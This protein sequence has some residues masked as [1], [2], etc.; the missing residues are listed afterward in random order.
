[1][2]LDLFHLS[3]DVDQFL[4]RYVFNCS[5]VSLDQSGEIVFW[6]YCL[7]MFKDFLDFDRLCYSFLFALT[8]SRLIRFISLRGDF[9]SGLFNVFSLR[10]LRVV[11]L[12]SMQF[13]IISLSNFLQTH[14]VNAL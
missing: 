13:S 9:A 8:Y 6:K 10:G 5:I 1:M 3:S 11:N 2:T 4:S 7:S 12:S 14:S